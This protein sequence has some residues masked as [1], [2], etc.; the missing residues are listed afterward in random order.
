MI[1]Q[2]KKSMTKNGGTLCADDEENGMIGLYRA[3][4]SVDDFKPIGYMIIECKNSYFS[5]KLQSVPSTYKNRFYLLNNDMD[6]IV[7]SEKNMYGNSF[8]LETRDF[9]NVKIVKDPSTGENSYFTYQYVNNGWL[10]VSTI[11]VGQLWK[12]I[13]IAL[14]S[15]LIN[16][17]HLCFGSLII[18]I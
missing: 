12:N 4:L 18:M 7:S 5:E 15:V 14:V 2:K 8:P 16:V 9:K 10:L 11:N 13:G 17:W 6:I 1:L 3:I